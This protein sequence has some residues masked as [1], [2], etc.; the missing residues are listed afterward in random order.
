MTL[1]LVTSY[2]LKNFD[3]SAVRM[4]CNMTLT[5]KGVGGGWMQVA[6]LDMTNSSHQC[7][8]GMR[9]RTD[10]PKRVCGINLNNQGYSSTTFD[11]HGIKYN[12]V[13]GKIIGYQDRTPDAFHRRPIAIDGNYVEGVSL[14]HGSNPRKHI[15]TFTASLDEVGTHPC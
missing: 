4:Y 15:W 14:T 6:K 2:W 5:C 7:P 9:L 11:T 10:L 3:G 12:Q 8:P 13:C 1:H